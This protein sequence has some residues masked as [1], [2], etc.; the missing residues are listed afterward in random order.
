VKIN[1]QAAMNIPKS[2]SGS[3]YNAPGPSLTSTSAPKSSEKAGDQIDLASQ[4]GLVSQIQSAGVDERASRVQELRAAVQSGQYQVDTA[5]LSQSV[6]TSM[7][8]GY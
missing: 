5:A 4:S 3:L 6:V 2:Q 1:E 8:N 7:L